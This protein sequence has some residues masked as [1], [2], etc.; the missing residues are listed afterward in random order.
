MAKE[1]YIG[2]SSSSRKVKQIYIGISSVAKKIK[3]A[4]IGVNNGARLW[5]KSAN[6]P[7]VNG[8]TIYSASNARQ[9]RKIDATISTYGL[10]LQ[11]DI[12]KESKILV[13]VNPQG[14]TKTLSQPIALESYYDTQAGSTANH[15]FVYSRQD[16]EMYDSN[17]VS[18][19]VAN[20]RTYLEEAAVASFPSKVFFFG[21]FFSDDSNEEAHIYADSGV[22]TYIQNFENSFSL[23][24]PSGVWQYIVKFNDRFIYYRGSG[25]TENYAPWRMI[26][27]N[28]VLAAT[29]SEYTPYSA[30]TT[31][32]CIDDGTI[33]YYVG[34]I[35]FS[36]YVGHLVAVRPSGV[37]SS[38][39]IDASSFGVVSGVP[40]VYFTYPIA[41]G[42][43]TYSPNFISGNETVGGILD[44]NGT[45]I[46]IGGLN[47]L[48]PNAEV[49]SYL[50]FSQED[51]VYVGSYTAI[52]KMIF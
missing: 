39:E 25:V 18:T 19:V 50:R 46:Y 4:Y 12:Y 40:R 16:V 11:Y 2:L 8:G 7:P 51:T 37:T 42:D 6:I 15:I 41:V 3:K 35:G 10:S 27:E 32:R 21:G 33:A 49:I 43:N 13:F 5:W 26:T 1:A 52:Y 28:I 9:A 38:T 29:G 20:N 44:R 47:Y 23:Y 24:D 17:L 30:A 31:V 48:N 36:F 14:V 45:I 34:G 22:Y